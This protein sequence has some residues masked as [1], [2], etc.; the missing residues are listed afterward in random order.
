M[1]IQITYKL[2]YKDRNQTKIVNIDNCVDN[3][4]ADNKF[5][6]WSKRKFKNAFKIEIV[7]RQ[8][9]KEDITLDYLKTMFNM[10]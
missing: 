5:H 9:I 4:H 1:K 8:E 2:F 6:N 10:N 7:D 3:T